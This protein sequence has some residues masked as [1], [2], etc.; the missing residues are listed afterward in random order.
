MD[1]DVSLLVYVVGSVIWKMFKSVFFS[2]FQVFYVCSVGIYS[3]LD[4]NPFGEQF[5]VYIVHSKGSSV[6]SRAIV[7]RYRY[8]EKYSILSSQCFL[9]LFCLVLVNRLP[10]ISAIITIDYV[11]SNLKICIFWRRR[12]FRLTSNAD[13]A[14][15]KIWWSNWLNDFS[16]I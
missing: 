7:Q 5:L 8:A 6:T 1:Y 16:R 4:S 11:L 12:T 3:Y 9:V 15:L 10:S 13:G 14:L 2:Q